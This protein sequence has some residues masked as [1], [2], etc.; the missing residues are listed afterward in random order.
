MNALSSGGLHQTGKDAVGFE[1][2]FR[3]RSEAYL[4]EDHQM[5]ERLFR[6]IVGGWYAGASEEGKEKSLFRAYEIATEGLGGFETERLFAEGV[7]FSDELFFDL[8]CHLPG[9]IA[10]FELLPCIAE[11]GA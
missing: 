2:I 3:S 11:S 10:G 7:E 9:D 8:G 6:M 1:S 5:P 4:S